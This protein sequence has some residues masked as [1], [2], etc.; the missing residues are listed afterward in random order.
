MGRMPAFQAWMAVLL[1]LGAAGAA[2]AQAPIAARA[3]IDPGIVRLGERA[4]YRGHVIVRPDA[5]VRWLVPEATEALTWG[6]RRA[7]PASSIDG[8]DAH[9]RRA[10][11][12]SVPIPVQG[13]QHGRYVDAEA[14]GLAMLIRMLQL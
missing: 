14:A 3:S 10:D 12:V 6:E 13:F 8:G 7:R 9:R 2:R 5:P 4:T 11:T 1:L